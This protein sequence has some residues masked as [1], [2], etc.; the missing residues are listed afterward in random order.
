MTQHRGGSGNF[1]DDKQRASEAGKKGGQHS[2]GSFGNDREK[3]SDAGKKGSQSGN[4]G[5]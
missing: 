3:A 2:G 5:T 1:A 4:R